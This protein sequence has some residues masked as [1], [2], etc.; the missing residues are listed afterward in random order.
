MLFCRTIKE[1][2]LSH[3]ALRPHA[4]AHKCPTIAQLQLQ[5][6]VDQYTPKPHV[7]TSG[8]SCQKV[9]HMCVRMSVYLKQ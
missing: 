6:I 5:S 1:K 3:I 7:H 8:V 2:E 9:G 4:K